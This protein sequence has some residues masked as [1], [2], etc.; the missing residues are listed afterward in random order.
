MIFRWNWMFWFPLQLQPSGHWRHPHH[1]DYHGMYWISSFL[2]LYVFQDA[3]PDFGKGSSCLSIKSRR[4]LNY[5]WPIVFILPEWTAINHKKT[6][7]NTHHG[8]L[9]DSRRSYTV[10]DVV[11]LML[12]TQIFNWVVVSN[13]FY[14]QPYLGKFSNLTNIIQ[15]GWNHQPVKGFCHL[16]NKIS[17]Q[18]KE[19]EDEPQV[20]EDEIGDLGEDGCF[21]NVCLTASLWL[22]SCDNPAIIWG[23]SSWVSKIINIFQWQWHVFTI[24]SW[25][26]SFLVDQV[27]LRKLLKRGKSNPQC[28]GEAQLEDKVIHGSSYDVSECLIFSSQIYCRS[29]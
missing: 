16:A 20:G 24:F 15:V 14:F 5:L 9:E 10:P 3:W 22:D 4:E 23:K 29:I 2:R 27:F 6:V 17:P 1:H 19:T 28:V 8:H 25:T 7:K 11:I 21:R 26:S 18:G 13:I 12:K